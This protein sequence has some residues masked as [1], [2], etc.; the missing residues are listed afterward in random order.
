VRAANR[1]RKAF[2]HFYFERY[3]LNQLS[4]LKEETFGGARKQTSKQVLNVISVAM[5]HGVAEKARRNMYELLQV[6][7]EQYDLSQ[8]LYKTFYLI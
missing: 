8:S 7:K 6:K 2:L 1:I 4:K 5:N 3:A